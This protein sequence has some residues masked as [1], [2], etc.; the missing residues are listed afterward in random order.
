MP[1]TSSDESIGSTSFESSGTQRGTQPEDFPPEL[2]SIEGLEYIGFTTDR[3]TEIFNRWQ[4]RPDGEHN[5]DDLWDYIWS[6]I[7]GLNYVFGHLAPPGPSTKTPAQAMTN[8]GIRQDVQDGILHRDWTWLFVTESLMYWLT[9]TLHVNYCHIVKM[10][11]HLQAMDGNTRG[12]GEADDRGRGKRPAPP[13]VL[14]RNIVSPEEEDTP[15]PSVSEMSTEMSTEV[16]AGVAAE[17]SAEAS[18]ELLIELSTELS[19]EPSTEA[20]TRESTEDS[21]SSYFKSFTTV[22]SPPPV[23]SGHTVLYKTKALSEL[24]AFPHRSLV[25]KNGNINLTCLRSSPPGDFH[26]LY[27]VYY[28]TPEKETA[29]I[30]MGYARVRNPGKEMLMI[31][32]QVPDG[33]LDR[34]DTKD[35]YF[36][37]SEWKEYVWYCRTVQDSPKFQHLLDADFIRGHILKMNTERLEGIKEEEVETAITYDNVMQIPHTNNKSTQWVFMNQRILRDLAEAIKGKIHITVTPGEQ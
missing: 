16:S 36:G 28:F 13:D 4:G 6:H 9:D 27:P 12:K 31:R 10:Q 29:D 7:M 26:G 8:L 21:N 30:Y 2:E 35:L 20:S 33:F 14:S 18:I 19:T 3:A 23:L 11:R 25:D 1:Y 15:P 17:V 22:D 34:Y 5:P 32:I 37:N 24:K